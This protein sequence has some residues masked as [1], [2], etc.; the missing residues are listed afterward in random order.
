MKIK[1]PV[2]LFSLFA[3]ASCDVNKQLAN[4]LFKP[5]QVDTTVPASEIFARVKAQYDI[6]DTKIK[7]YCEA[8]PKNTH[9]TLLTLDEADL[10][11]DNIRTDQAGGTLLVAVFKP[12]YTISS[13]KETTITFSLTNTAVAP[14]E[15]SLALKVDS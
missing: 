4:G 5:L 6:A 15:K 3:F 11:L 13:K 7:K 9:G 10:I 14:S 8:I 1:F 2:L 12:G